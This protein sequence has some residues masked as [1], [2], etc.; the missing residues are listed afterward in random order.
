M[1]STVAILAREL[2]LQNRYISI[3][4]VVVV[5]V[6]TSRK[7]NRTESTAVM[8]HGRMVD[9]DAPLLPPNSVV[10]TLL[11]LWTAVGGD[12]GT[13]AGDCESITISSSV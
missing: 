9:A 12:R 6:Y 3:L 5:V 10:K 4:V 1:F 13:S 11:V 8:P 2:A 7:S